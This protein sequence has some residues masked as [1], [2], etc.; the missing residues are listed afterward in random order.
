MTVFVYA[1][2][3][4][5]SQDNN[6]YIDDAVLQVVAPPADGHP[7]ADQHAAADRAPYGDTRAHGYASPHRHAGAHCD[8]LAHS[9]G[10]GDAATHQ[11][12]AAFGHGNTC[13]RRGNDNSRAQRGA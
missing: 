7:P 11:D 9:D 5:R 12:A 8:A 6:V 4:F 2:P 10:D 13:S 3:E 1:Y